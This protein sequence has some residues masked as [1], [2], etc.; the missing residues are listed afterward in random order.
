MPEPHL[1]VGQMARIL[2]PEALLF[3]SVDIGGVPTPDEPIVFSLETLT[4]LLQE[5]FAIVR[6]TDDHP[7]H[8]GWRAGSVRPVAHKKPFASKTLDKAQILQAYR[9]RLGLQE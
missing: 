9:A 6:M 3:L 4:G 5:H 1:A 2:K 7:A 8:N